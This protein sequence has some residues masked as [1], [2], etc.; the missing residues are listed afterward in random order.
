MDTRV[1][2][3]EQIVSAWNSEGIVYAVAHGIE[4]Y[5]HKLGRD[6]DVFVKKHHLEKA[7]K[8]VIEI[9][10]ENFEVVIAPRWDVWSMRQI[11]AFGEENSL[12]IDLFTGLSWGPVYLVKDVNPVGI[13]NRF[14][15]FDPWVSFAKNVLLKI[16]G[17]INPFPFIFYSEYEEVI[18]RQCELLF[19]KELTKRLI[20]SLRRG[21]F[22]EIK[23]LISDLRRTVI[24]RTFILYP[25]KSI[26]YSLCWFIK[27]IRLYF[28]RIFPIVVIFGL[29][30][31]IEKE[32]ISGKF[33][34]SLFFTEII[35]KKPFSSRQGK[36]IR[37]LLSLAIRIVL[38]RI[39]NLMQ[40]NY[41]LNSMKFVI[42]DGGNLFHWQS[43]YRKLVQ[44]GI[45][46]DVI[47]LLDD[48]NSEEVLTR[49]GK[50]RVPIE[51]VDGK[52]SARNIVREIRKIFIKRIAMRYGEEIT[53]R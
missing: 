28:F 37:N 43:A 49:L 32:L 38:K 15:K 34:E 50:V 46:P 4:G 48:G 27:K 23:P 52:M 26:F 44:L 14:F 24:A 45:K 21:D 51:V 42:Y 41:A 33:L 10:K 19:G 2:V 25:L 13:V 20:E 11:F 36:D 40:D 12:Q 17:G 3:I 29:N 9:L 6:I 5:P 18:L 53:N 31:K 16:L 7:R 1:R 35:I 8:L 39:H 30:E 22:I 47:V